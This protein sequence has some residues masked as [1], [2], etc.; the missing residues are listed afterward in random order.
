MEI[1]VF[2]LL[3][4]DIALLSVGDLVPVDGIFI[5]GYGIKC[6]ESSATGESDLMKKVPA[7]TVFAALSDVAEGKA[8][9][10]N[11]D[12][13]D[14][15]IISGSKV[16]EGS[17]SFL[18]TAVGVNSSYGS[19][20]MSL[21]TEQEDTPL[22][23]KL[24]VLAD[25][26][27]IFGGGA[28]LVLFLALFIKFA[29]G[30]PTN[31]ST[32]DE[33]GKQFLELFV[34]SVTVVVVAVPEGLPLAVTLA[35]AFATTR[36]M[37]D[38]NLVRILKACET[39]GNA[40][41]ICSDK[42]GTL[43]QNK[44]TVVAATLGKAICFGDKDTALDADRVPDGEAPAGSIT[45]VSVG[46]FVHT[47]ND[48][49]KQLIV[50]SNAVNST[51]FEGE[52]DGKMTYIGSTT[53]VAL[54]TFSRDHLA[55]G[56]V[57]Q[58][59]ENAT[60][61]QQV[62]F[63]SSVKFMASVVKLTNGK[64]R[65]YVK[66]ASEIV[67]DKC[68]QT[69]ADTGGGDLVSVEMTEE[70]VELFKQKIAAYAGQALRTIGSAYRDFDSW[71]PEGAEAADDPKAAD[72]SKV[73]HHM[74][75]V[76]IFGIQDPLRPTV[77]DALNDCRRAGIVVRMVTGDN[78]LTGSAIAQECG[79]YRPEQGGIAMEGPVFRRKTE[80]ELKEIVPHLQV[81]A[82]S[83]PEDKRIL[84]QTLKSLGETVAVTG[85]GTNDAPALKLA[86]VGF[87]MG[88]AGTEVAKEAADIILLDD[89]FASIVKA[90][91]WGRA[92]NDSVKKFLQ[93]SPQPRVS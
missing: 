86:D 34:V 59:R 76:N 89:N 83:S 14:P 37:K 39:M 73:H 62:P 8:G 77:I 65:A 68:T 56:P 11:I 10:I 53:E 46:E 91:C 5:N 63:D 57:Q 78:I 29:A 75:L 40:T 43:T 1:S 7:D 20:S 55:A 48:E 17:G 30:L 19:I 61:V 15:F 69:I 72:F 12:K 42:T 49:T 21:R 27:A 82:R 26:I 93:V 25:K 18:V 13:L 2:D 47:L 92:V 66:G 38:N 52:Q 50:Q 90:V 71:P 32:A 67:L 88:I 54:L 84:V 44:M 35:L 64:F 85:D 22:Q 80:S 31:H 3:V 33:K 70:D 16:Q 23:K 60:I 58:E 81:L 41:A 9:N 6:D 24:N 4:G 28:A 87:A 51:A 45:S 79:I 36:M 74:T